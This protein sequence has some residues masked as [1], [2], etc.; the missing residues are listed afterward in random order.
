MFFKILKKKLEIFLSFV[1]LKEKQVSYFSQGVIFFWQAINQFRKS[2]R[3]AFIPV[4][5]ETIHHRTPLCTTAI[6]FFCLLFFG[7]S[8]LSRNKRSFFLEFFKNISR[9]FLEFENSFPEFENNIPWFRDT[10]SGFGNT[11][12][13]FRNTTPGFWKYFLWVKT[14]LKNVRLI[15]SDLCFLLLGGYDSWNVIWFLEMVT[16]MN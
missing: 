16:N 9:L 6:T 7:Y 15:L 2:R 14:N 10:I 3:F 5:T 8:F 11:I 1:D 4:Y 12:P 13:R